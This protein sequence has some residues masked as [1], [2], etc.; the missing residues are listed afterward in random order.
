MSYLMLRGESGAE[1]ALKVQGVGRV[2]KFDS[3]WVSASVVTCLLALSLYIYIDIDRLLYRYRYREIALLGEWADIE[4]DSQCVR[5][6]LRE[7]LRH[8]PPTCSM[9]SNC[10]GNPR[11]IR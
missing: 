4:V 8:Y 9:T 10:G 6:L 11:G 1:V 3:Y 5:L 2:P 7:C